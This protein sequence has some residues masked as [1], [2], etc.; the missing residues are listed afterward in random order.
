[1]YCII[2]NRYMVPFHL[3]IRGRN[4]MVKNRIKS[5]NGYIFL[6]LLIGLGFL[7]TGAAYIAQ[8]YRLLAILDGNTVNLISCGVH[9]VCQAVGIGAVAWLFAKRPSIAGGKV[10]PLC[11]TVLA[12]ICTALSLHASSLMLILIFG[13]L[14]NLAIGVLSGCYLTRLSTD[15]PQQR[16]GLVFGCAYALG[17]IGTWLV[18]LPMD[19]SFL[20]HSRSFLA[21]TALAALTV[22]LILCL[23]A[24][25]F[26]ENINKRPHETFEK[27][28]IF[29]AA[30]VLF[31]LSMEN[32]LGF[33]FPLKS[34]SGSVY[35]EFTRVFYGI[36]LVVAGLVSDKSRRYGAICCLAAL[37]FPFGALALGSN[38]T[39]ETAMWI[40]AYLF[41][42]FWSVYRLLVFSDV[43]CRT[44]MPVFAVF[45]LL[46]GR[47]GEATGTLGVG[48]FTGTMLIVISGAVFVLVIGLFF[49][50]Y[51]KLYISVTSPEK[52]E[53]Q[54]F[55]AYTTHFG[56]SAREREIFALLIRGMS[57]AEIA[58][59]L[60]ITESTVKFHIGNMFKKSGF[61]RRTEFI[62][63]Y[64][65]GQTR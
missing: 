42:G 26:Q 4:I 23:S 51:Q 46:F 25:P 60:Y 39:G 57:N 27:K 20:W 37:A 58:G 36:G 15:I 29:L 21:I 47:L 53:Q 5:V 61:T 13:S 44:G 31:L 54:R 30:V 33:A 22:P 3:K 6:I 50:L 18:S 8:A 48:L 10:I 1:M 28:L 55:V 19:G 14:L 40:L 62:T 35:I 41:L 65:L 63:D 52:L 12:I 64:M 43:A 24:P 16:R 45:G 11:T 59:E 32:T 9:Y 56:F 38:V 49:V 7:W 17:S 34:A 2:K